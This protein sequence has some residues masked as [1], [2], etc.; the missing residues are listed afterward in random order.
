LQKDYAFLIDTK[1]KRYRVVRHEPSKEVAM[2]PWTKS[3]IIK[4]GSEENVLE[5]RDKGDTIELYINDQLV[6]SIKDLYGHPN[7]VPG[8]YAGDAAKIGFKKLEI[9]K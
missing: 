6:T 8:L 7:G 1:L 9:R 5:A 2:V 4:E 3:N